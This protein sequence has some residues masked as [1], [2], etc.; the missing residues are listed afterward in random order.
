MTHNTNFYQP[1]TSIESL[2]SLSLLILNGSVHLDDYSEAD[3]QSLCE[4]LNQAYR[5]GTPVVSDAEYDNIFLAALEARNPANPFLNTVEPEQPLTVGPLVRHASPMLSTSKAYT[6]DEVKRFVERVLAT[7]LDLG[8][9][10]EEVRFCVTPK[11]DGMAC[12]D[13]GERLATRGDGLSGSDVTHILERGAVIAGPGKR[14]LGAGEIVVDQQYFL[15]VLKPQF[16]LS[17]PRNYITGFCGADT[18]KVHHQ[19][20]VA[21][22]AVVFVPYATLKHLELTA[23]ELIDQWAGLCDLVAGEVPYLTDGAVVE[24]MDDAI[25]ESMGATSHHHRWMLAIKKNGETAITTARSI[26]WQTG[27]TG[28]VTPVVELDTIELSGAKIS[29]ATAHNAGTVKSLG[30]GPGA[31][32]EIVRSG[33]VIPKIER[34]VQPVTPCLPTQCPSCEHALVWDNDFL[35]CPN[36]LV[37]EKQVETGLGHFFQILGN[38]DLFGPKTIE[39]LVSAGYK[40]LESIYALTE[41]DFIQA[42]FGPGQSQNLVREVARSKSQSVEDWRFLAAFGVHHLGRGDAR[43]LLQGFSL[44]DLVAGV[45]AQDISKLKGFGD[46]TSESIARQLIERKDTIAHLL[47]MFTL[48]RTGKAS[49]SVEDDTLP[50]D[51]PIKGKGVVFTGK[52]IT[53]SREDLQEA[54]RSLGA[55]VQSSVNSKTDYLVC[56]DKVGASKIAKAEKLNV[57]VLTEAE[58]VTLLTQ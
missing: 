44:E 42:G 47:P 35:V 32:I 22:Q 24:V 39:T 54:A 5:Q 45:S 27:R 10:A 49:L 25:T 38:V 53:G 18:L 2:T 52:L 11:L 19:E 55:N 37:C 48:R 6:E 7:A 26:T 8:I 50:V 30:I 16:G 3:L 14:G 56:G 9:D 1:A 13:D 4:K 41:Q 20:A 36:G 12:R 31:Q 40:D 33:S 23:E 58:Y 15:D 34:V 29:R 43:K 46:V 17:H 57:T 21:A 28:R 51:S